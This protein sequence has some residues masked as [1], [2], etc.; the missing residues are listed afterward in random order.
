MKEVVNFHY[1]NK[2][3]NMRMIWFLED[4]EILSNLPED[5]II[6][7]QGAKAYNDHS[8]LF[9]TL[10]NNLNISQEELFSNIS[11]GCRYE[12]KRGERENI[13][14]DVF[15]SDYLKSNIN[16][17][18]DFI[19]YYNKF[20]ENKGLIQLK[21][22]QMMRF[23]ENNVLEISLAKYNDEI[24]VYHAYIKDNSRVRLLCSAS[25][26]RLRDDT[27]SLIGWANRLLH[28]KDMLHYKEN[29]FSIYDW[30][31]IAIDDPSGK[32]AGINKFK[33]EFGGNEEEAYDFI[34]ANTY[35]AKTCRMLYKLLRS[36]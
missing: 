36:L 19:V 14:T 28:W 26:F 31:G 34:I 29:N 21:I 25:M 9:T 30:G 33:L 22:N 13:Q 11:K 20:A 4:Y 3:L 8:H 6:V 2:M 32:M 12:I 15:D 27:K 5:F 16:E 1:K 24:L 23:L 17:L 10:V 7:R 35:K 18:N